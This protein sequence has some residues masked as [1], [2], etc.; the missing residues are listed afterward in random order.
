MVILYEDVAQLHQQIP[1]LV[2]NAAL[3]HSLAPRYFKIQE[4]LFAEFFVCE[5][6]NKSIGAGN[7]DGLPSLSL[8]VLPSDL[9]QLP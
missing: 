4:L 9:I 6:H 7:F 8:P 5:F 3:W 1:H 2:P